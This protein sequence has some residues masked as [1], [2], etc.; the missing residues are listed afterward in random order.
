MQG[1]DLLLGYRTPLSIIWKNTQKSLLRKTADDFHQ[2]SMDSELIWKTYHSTT[3][4]HRKGCKQTKYVPSPILISFLNMSSYLRC[5]QIIFIWGWISVQEKQAYE[6]V[7]KW[8]ALTEKQWR[9]S[10]NVP[11]ICLSGLS[12]SQNWKCSSDPILAVWAGLDQPLRNYLSQL[13]GAIFKNRTCFKNFTCNWDKSCI[14]FCGKW[15]HLQIN[16]NV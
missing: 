14:K 12:S 4:L 6:S 7:D 8:K 5:S 15:S 1:S 2:I 10:T 11:P 16:I 13:K 9:A 3:V